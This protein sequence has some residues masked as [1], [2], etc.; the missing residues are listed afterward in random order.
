M[1]PLD[2]AEIVDRAWYPGALG[3]PVHIDPTRWGT[4]S[5]DGNVA[6]L[7]TREQRAYRQEAIERLNFNWNCL[8]AFFQ[9]DPSASGPDRGWELLARALAE[10]HVP[11]LRLDTAPGPAWKD[12]NPLAVL[13]GN[14]PKEAG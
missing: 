2:L 8:C 1:T 10:R 6:H 7:L 5:R 14:E 12:N 9:I 4:D 3:R 11:G 13:L